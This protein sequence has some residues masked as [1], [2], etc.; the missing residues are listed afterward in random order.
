[1]DR[2]PIKL[3]LILFFWVGIGSAVAWDWNEPFKELNSEKLKVSAEGRY[4]MEYRS[5]FDFSGASDV[6]QL[7]RLRLNADVM[8]LENLRLFVQAQDARLYESDFDGAAE[9]LFQDRFDLRQG[10][11]ELKKI[12]DLP[13]SLLV[14]RQELA[15]GEE[16]LVGGFNWSNVAQTFDAVRGRYQTDAVQIDLFASEKVRIE[17]DHFNERDHNDRFYGI[18]GTYKKIKNHLVDLYVFLRDTD[19]KRRFSR[20]EAP[21]EMDEV[22]FGSRVK[23]WDLNGWDYQ[24]EI[25]GQGGNYGDGEIQAFALISQVGYTFSSCAL[26]P[27]PF[28][29]YAHASGDSDPG[30]GDRGTFD[31]LFP[32]NHAFYGLA[33][34]VSLQ[35]IND[36]EFG[37]D[38]KPTEKLKLTCSLHLFYLDE[39]EDALYNAG[40]VPIRFDAT[41]KASTTVGQEVDFTAEYTLNAHASALLGY[42]HFFTGEF[43]D[44]T[45]ADHDPDFLYVQLSLKY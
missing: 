23:G 18:Y 2:K 11:V 36:F 29:E 4:R 25:A 32:T 28:F 37:L 3:S 35:N 34:F 42:S 10:F 45:G 9:D 12:F 40:R 20:A 41:G 24:L 38:L 31:N 13:V 21:A 27:H 44:D 33:D 39:E 19:K 43:I 14:G 16:R 17:D 5:D 8:P 6:F 15:Y 22:T 7:S 26:K 30:D 1:M